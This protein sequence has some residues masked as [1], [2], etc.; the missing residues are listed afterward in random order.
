MNIGY[1]IRKRRE[2]LGLSAEELGKRIGKA[3]TTIYR[4]EIG[5]IENMPSTILEPIAKALRTT[6]AY[7]MGWEANAERSLAEQRQE[8]KEKSYIQQLFDLLPSNRQSMLIGI[9]E[10]LVE[11]TGSE[12]PINKRVTNERRG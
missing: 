8:E 9:A 12:I 11:E 2:D 1:R 7:L 10:S 3:K 5:S 4:Y 6:P